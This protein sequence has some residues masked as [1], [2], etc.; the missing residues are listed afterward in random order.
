MRSVTEN[1]RKTVPVG[2]R[3]QKSF[4]R[5][6]DSFRATPAVSPDRPRNGLVVTGLRSARPRA[7]SGSIEIGDA[8]TVA[9]DPVGI[10]EEN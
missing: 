1:W 6:F 4:F 7:P 3:C 9:T 8:E 10:G 2:A 5:P